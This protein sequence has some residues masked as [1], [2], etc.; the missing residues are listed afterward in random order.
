[1]ST[2]EEDGNNQNLKLNL[3]FFSD[4][5]LVQNKRQEERNGNLQEN[6]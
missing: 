1:M 3:D 6:P 4:L 5:T 2:I